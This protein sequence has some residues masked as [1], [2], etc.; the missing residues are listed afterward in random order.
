[1]A[2]ERGNAELADYAD[3]LHPV[4]LKLIRRVAD[5]AH[6]HGKYVSVCGELAADPLAV[7]VLTGLGVDELSLAPHAV[8][9][10][11]AIIGKLDLKM[12]VDLVKKMLA[13]DNAGNARSLAEEFFR[14]CVKLETNL[15]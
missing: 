9:E 8:A 6:R 4:I 15:P 1:M 5:A 3:A 13:T 11:K 10:V 12:A 14:T 7:P 2:A